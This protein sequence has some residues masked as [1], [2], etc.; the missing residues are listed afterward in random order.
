MSKIEIDGA[1]KYSPDEFGAQDCGKIYMIKIMMRQYFSNN[2]FL[3]ILSKPVRMRLKFSGT[4]TPSISLILRDIFIYFT[5]FI[6]A[7]YKPIIGRH[8]L[9]LFE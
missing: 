7:A 4:L 9:S 8:D 1:L 2:R 3:I 6:N 5:N